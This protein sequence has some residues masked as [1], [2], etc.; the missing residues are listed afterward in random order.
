MEKGPGSPVAFHFDPLI[1]YPGWETDYRQTVAALFEAVPP[2]TI[3]W[4][5]LGALRFMPLLKAIM[6]ARFP[7]SRIAE[8][9]FITALDGKQRYF[10]TLRIEMYS[11]LREWIT[12][13]AP[14]VLIYLCMES[15]S[16]WE[17][18]FGFVPAKGELARLLDRQVLKGLTQP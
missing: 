18:V 9:E 2:E 8:E 12:R 13:Q 11:R 17:A 16:V 7:A 4:I 15:P 6:R 5:S 3:A 1:Y 14:E 10:K